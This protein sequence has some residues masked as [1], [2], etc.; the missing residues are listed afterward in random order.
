H[1]PPIGFPG[2]RR[3]TVSVRAAPRNEPP[4]NRPRAPRLPHFGARP[5]PDV[6]AL[7]PPLPPAGPRAELP[8]PPFYQP[9]VRQRRRTSVLL[10]RDS[11]DSRHSVRNARRS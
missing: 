6:L 8:A 9:V 10:D 4:L 1:R 5:F 2:Q 11:H 7:P 3:H